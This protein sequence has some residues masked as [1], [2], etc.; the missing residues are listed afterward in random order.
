M[1]KY[2]LIIIGAGPSG[3]TAA[4]YAARYKLKT[5]VLSKD[6]GGL[7]ATAHK[8]CNF[9]SYKEISGMDLMMKFIEQVQE[10]KVPII[11]EPVLNISKKGKNDFLVKTNKNKYFAK[12]IIFS[13]G[14]ERKKLDV[15][16]EKE[17]CGKGV[18]YCATCDGP[19]FKDKI[20]S[21]IGGS[22]AALTAALLLT[23]YAKKVYIIYRK[24]KFF[25]AEPSWID[26]VNK[27]KNIE[28]I[29]SDEITKII[30]KEKVE[31]I[32]LKSGKE[33]IME[34][35]FIEVGSLPDLHSLEE[36]KIKTNEK[37]YII[38]NNNQETNVHGFYA[39]GDI[40]N[41][42]LKQIIT[43]AA[44]GANAAHHAYQEI[45]QEN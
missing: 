12:K 17:L 42:R 38:V 39:A 20:V 15:P 2:D 41:G 40:T 45:K 13:G 29:F 27:E 10:L 1:E 11:Y 7:A 34:G 43:G 19:F 5:L 25:R 30:G 9:P 33:L 26:L 21:V 3:L 44:Q 31:K 16:G 8:I 4:V 14:T 6:M 37:G 18:S 24:D 35:I 23:D 28:K 22:D 32:K 36:L